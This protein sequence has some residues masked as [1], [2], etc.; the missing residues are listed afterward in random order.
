RSFENLCAERSQRTT[1]YSFS[2]SVPMSVR[3]FLRRKVLTPAFRT[4]R[5]LDELAHVR[6][7]EIQADF[8]S[9]LS[10]RLILVLGI[11]LARLLL[12][13]R[14]PRGPDGRRGAD[15][16]RHTSKQCPPRNR[17]S[18]THDDPSFPLCP[19]SCTAIIGRHA[20]IGLLCDGRF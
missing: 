10:L 6:R 13:G 4:D 9:L 20:N 18:I 16:Q 17:L 1:N 11:R 14:P 7:L 3:V 15:G 12:C 2:A 8:A 19:F 5:A